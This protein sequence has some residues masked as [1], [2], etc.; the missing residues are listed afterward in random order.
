VIPRAS[1]RALALTIAITATATLAA[2]SG[3]GSGGGGELTYEDSPLSKYLEAANGGAWDEERA[4]A[5]QQQ[6]EELVAACMADEGFEYL[7]VDHSQNMSF[8]DDMEERNTEEWVAANGWGMVQTE[9]EM[10]EQQAEAEEFVDPNQPYVQSLSPSE[11]EAYFATLYGAP[12]SEEEMTEDGAVEYNWEDGGCQ[13]A[14][15]HE[16]QGDSYWED[17][18]FAGLVEDMNALWQDLPKQPEIVELNRQWSECMADAG[19]PD[20]ELR[21]DAQTSISDEMNAFWEGQENPEGPGADELKALKE[22]EIELALADF[23]CAKKL[24]YD[25]TQ[26]RAQFALEEQFIEDHQAEL[27]ELLAV[28]AKGE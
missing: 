7:P 20:F 12:P 16:V 10:K 27:D 17:E 2:C 6:V 24:D 14:A 1:A 28:Y 4:I 5:Q 13:G 8:M 11:Q 3:G 21:W 25:T 18:R 9:E 26:F 22:K 19:H 23:R 15:N